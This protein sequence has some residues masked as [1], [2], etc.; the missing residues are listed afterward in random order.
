MTAMAGEPDRGAMLKESLKQKLE[1]F[2]PR[3]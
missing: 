1:E 2:I 3:R